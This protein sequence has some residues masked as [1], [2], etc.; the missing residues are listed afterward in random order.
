MMGRKLFIASLLWALLIFLVVH[1]SALPG[2]VPAFVEASGGGVLLDASPSFSPDDL[3]HRLEDYGEQGRRN[4]FFRNLTT[5]ILLPLS[6]LPFLYLLMLHAL[7][8]VNMVNS[9]RI[10]LL[11]LPFIYVIFDFAEN[12]AVL[13]LLSNFPKRTDPIATTLPYLTAIKRIASVLSLIIPISIYALFLVRKLP[14]WR[15]PNS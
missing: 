10:G 8:R 6:L 11:C 4:Y 3:Y 12:A 5:D 14:R 1:F 9:V 15:S 13:A 2:S 7:A